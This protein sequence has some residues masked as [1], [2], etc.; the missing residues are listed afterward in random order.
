[1]NSRAD[2]L[3]ALGQSVWLD[4]IRRGHMSSGDFESL[5]SNQGV[6]G[7][8][9]NP[10]IFQKAI[11]D[12][13][14]YDAFIEK[15]VADGLTGAP[16]FEA[17]MVEDIQMACDLLAPVFART[18]GCDGRVSIEVNPHLAR[19]TQGT[20]DEARRLREAVAR[21]NV[22]IKVPATREGLPAVTQLIADG[23]SVNVTLIFTLERYDEVMEAYLAGLEKRHAAGGAL[24]GVRSVASFFVSRVDTK[25]D[26]AIE[27]K[28]EQL[29]EGR[30]EREV[31][32][33]L[34][35]MA[36]VANARL[37]YQAFKRTFGSPR[38]K[39]LSEA[40]AHVQRP[41]WASTSTKNPEYRDVIYVEELIGPETVNTMPLNTLEA[42]NEHGTVE[43]RIEQ[44][45]DAAEALF[46]RLPELGIPI[47][48]LIGELEDEGLAAF[49]KSFDDA[50]ETLE[51]KRH[52]IQGA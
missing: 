8:T 24:D 9:S 28:V 27:A 36:A 22:M 31:L 38:F 15:R 25:V 40:G 48:S 17:L 52:A 3:N 35:G 29:E 20:I 46:R 49:E 37:A 41:L 16:L 7:V 18:N 44:D 5:V 43:A 2:Q 14:D 50:L 30:A 1:M 33:G 34:R 26:K 10:T 13:D 23:I 51:T 42:F 21:E 39:T 19:D 12:S 45:V 6:V 4:F 32:A 11:G 47:D